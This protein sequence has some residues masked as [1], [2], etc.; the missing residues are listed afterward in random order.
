MPL[1]NKRLARRRVW[2]FYSIHSESWKLATAS[3]SA[4]TEEYWAEANRNVMF[5]PMVEGQEGVDNL[6]EILSM[7]GT[8][9]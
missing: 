3:T 2:R 9:T 1:M 4:F 5:V 6:E 7:E 8:H